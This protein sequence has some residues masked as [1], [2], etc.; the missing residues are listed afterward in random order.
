[1]PLSAAYSLIRDR[2]T[3]IKRREVGVVPE[4]IRVVLRSLIDEKTLTDKE[5]SLIIKFLQDRRRKLKAFEN[6]TNNIIG[7]EDD[8]LNNPGLYLMCLKSE[9]NSFN[10]IV[11]Y[12]N[13]CR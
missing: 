8:L 1:M 10:F 2:Y 13:R 5:Y 7:K 12:N 11:F 3:E 6:R 4:N 9:L